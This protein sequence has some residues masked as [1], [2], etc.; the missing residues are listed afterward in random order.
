M[1][2]LVFYRVSLSGESPKYASSTSFFLVW[3]LSLE[4][5]LAELLGREVKIVLIF[6]SLEVQ[7]DVFLKA[8]GK[9]CEGA[10]SNYCIK[11]N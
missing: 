2:L 9:G 7:G 11:T 5:K 4:F 8:E 3:F 6:I 10:R 1:T